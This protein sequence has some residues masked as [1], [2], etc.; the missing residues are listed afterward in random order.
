MSNTTW[1]ARAIAADIITQIRAGALTPGQPLPSRRNLAALYEVS[2]TTIT[3][4]LALLSWSGWIVGHKGRDVRV[5][6]PTP[7]TPKA[8]PGG[9][10]GPSAS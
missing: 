6:N 9:P 3:R 8:P 10:E 5:T 7:D 1:G 2:E 4:A